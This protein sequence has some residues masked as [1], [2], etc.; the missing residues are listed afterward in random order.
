MCNDQTNTL[1]AEADVH[2]SLTTVAAIAKKYGLCHMTLRRYLE[3]HGIQA[4]FIL[5]TPK[6]EPVL[7]FVPGRAFAIAKAMQDDMW[8]DRPHEMV[9]PPRYAFRVSEPD[10][11]FCGVNLHPQ[12]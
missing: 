1:T 8:K 6:E 12:T 3:K 10:Q 2:F 9:A 4:D 7:C 11:T 5:E